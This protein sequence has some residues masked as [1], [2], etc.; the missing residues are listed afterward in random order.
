MRGIFIV[1]VSDWISAFASA[2]PEKLK[3]GG[4][5]RKMCEILITKNSQKIQHNFHIEVLPE[6]QRRKVEENSPSMAVLNT[7]P[8]RWT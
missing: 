6:C 7:F 4:A 1:V 5:K 3:E 2:D 8:L